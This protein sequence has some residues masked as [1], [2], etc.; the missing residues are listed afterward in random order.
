MERATIILDAIGNSI[1]IN[2]NNNT[3]NY[4]SHALWDVIER[5]NKTIDRLMSMLELKMIPNKY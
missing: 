1:I 4:G 3:I 5:Q 2:G